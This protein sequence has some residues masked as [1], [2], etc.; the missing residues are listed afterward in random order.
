M[1]NIDEI[2]N[3]IICGDCLEVLKDIPDKSI[4]MVMTSPPYYSLRNYQVEGQIG[5]EE[6]FDK[7]LNKLLEIFA[8]IKRVL[9]KSGSFWLNMGDT[10]KEKCM[11][12]QPERTALKMIDEQEWWLRQK[13]IWTKQVLI[14]KENK[15]IGSVMPT[16][17]KDRFNMSWEYLFHFVKN[18]KYYFNLD[19]VRIPAQVVGVTDLRPAGI[20]RQRMY[21]ESKYNKF[22]YRVRDAERKA[23]QPQFRATKE[24]IEK[25]KRD[26]RKEEAE[27]YRMG[28]VDPHRA[29]LRGGLK[30]YKN[31]DPRGNDEGGP[32]SYRLWKDKHPYQG[33]FSGMGE[34][35]VEMFGSPRARNERKRN[36]TLI[37]PNAKGLR[38]APE[39]GEPNA[40]HPLGKNI[41]TVWQINPEPHNFQKEVGVDT[42]HFATYPQELCRIPILSSCPPDGIVL[43]PF[44]GSGTTLL[45]AKKLGR[46]YIGIELNPNYCKIAEKRLKATPTPLL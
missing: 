2:K 27:G 28:S 45:V 15:T 26:W 11:M 33:K 16:S 40:F 19:A 14:N 38:Q 34:E 39:P 18:K 17:T 8:E 5:L 46:N 30:Y 43:D 31:P 36:K 13:I 7:Y 25:Y 29:A 24:E 22:N 20:L 32:G 3:K 1:Y 12:M 37:D 4:D 6:N 35:E 23:R 42:D 21:P 44:A 41:P 10:F 9:K